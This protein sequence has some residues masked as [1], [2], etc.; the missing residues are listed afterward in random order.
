MHT[1]THNA[2]DLR[3]TQLLL[4]RAIFGVC[5]QS[6]SVTLVMYSTSKDMQTC[7]QQ[8]AWWLWSVITLPYITWLTG[9]IWAAQYSL[10]PVCFCFRPS[11]YFRPPDNVVSLAFCQRNTT[12][13]QLSCL[14]SCCCDA[15]CERTLPRSSK[16]E[17]QK[18]RVPKH[19]HIMWVLHVQGRLR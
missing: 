1:L 16:Q 13:A 8:W 12:W 9:W 18:T 7:D 6:S 14:S 17:D 10:Y 3:W 5:W 15:I 11:L 19:T 2:C 4:S